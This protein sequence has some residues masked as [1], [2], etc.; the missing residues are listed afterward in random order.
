MTRGD[1]IEMY[2]GCTLIL[3]LSK[4][5]EGQR[6]IVIARQWRNLTLQEAADEHGTT[7][8]RAHQLERAGLERLRLILARDAPHFGI[9]AA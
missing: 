1:A 9:A 5:A 6:H 4:L 3:A 2:I 7:K 8:Q